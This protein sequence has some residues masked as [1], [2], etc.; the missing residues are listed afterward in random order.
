MKTH[1][2]DMPATPILYMRRIGA[3]GEGNY[4]LMQD[5]K[6]WIHLNNLWNESGTLYG[7]AQDNMA[8]IP[9]EQCRYDVCFATNQIFE[10]DSILHGTLPMGKYLVV[11]IPHTTEAV[12]HFWQSIEDNVQNEGKQ[13][14]VSRPILERYQIALVEHGLCEFCIPILC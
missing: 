6:E 7:I 3:Y 14:D 12:Q 13:I 8:V 1:I 11:E 4:K 10:G 2:E 5:M 9:P